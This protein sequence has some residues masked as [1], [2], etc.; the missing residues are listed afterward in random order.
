MAKDHVDEIVAQWHRERPDVD[1]S[2]MEI[3]GRIG[4]LDRMIRPRLR[5]TFA[6][7]GLEDW[8][9]D[10]LATLRRNGAPHRLT[11]GQLLES[12]MITS[13]TMTN[14][15]DRLEARGL[16]SRA[17]DPDDARVVLVGLTPEG[18]ETI[19]A[20]VV[21]HAANEDRIL[22]GLEPAKRQ[23]LVELLRDLHLAV[24]ALDDGDDA[25]R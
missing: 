10:V 21:D 8:E 7:H 23:Q 20:A 14:R 9:F 12:M 3:I 17:K 24:E 4:R 13:G 11:A 16:V 2:G 18:L 25:G 1:V 19:D 15:I 22:S 6:R 5:S